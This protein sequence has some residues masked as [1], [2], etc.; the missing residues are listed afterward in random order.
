V[1]QRRGHARKQ[2]LLII[3]GS[4]CEQCG[5]DKKHCCTGISSH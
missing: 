5:C 1:Q 2:R 4:K 3:K